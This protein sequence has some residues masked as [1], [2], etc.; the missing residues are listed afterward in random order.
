MQF[1]GQAQGLIQDAPT[2]QEIVDRIMREAVEV[3]ENIDDRISY[4]SVANDE[5][6]LVSGQ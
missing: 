5:G 3:H 4:G 6:E 1:I 2:V